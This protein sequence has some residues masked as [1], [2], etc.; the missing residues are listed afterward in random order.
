MQIYIY[1]YRYRY[2]CT[3][4]VDVDRG[5]ELSRSKTTFSWSYQSLQETW[6]FPPPAEVA[7]KCRLLS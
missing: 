5:S 6:R 1:T 2:R 3:V 7:A 4:D